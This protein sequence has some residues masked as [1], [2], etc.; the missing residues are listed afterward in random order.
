MKKPLAIREEKGFRYYETGK[1]DVL[2]LLHGLF[3]ALSNFREVIDYFSKKMNVCIPLLPLYQLPAEQTTVEGLVDYIT[4]FIRHKRYKKLILLG[5]SLGGHIA[6]MYALQHP[7]KVRSIV[8]TG[9]SG[10]FENALGDSYPKKSDYDFVRQKT[11]YT[12][13]DPEVAT[14]ELVDEVYEIV[15]NREKALRILYL[16]KSALR[17]N[18]R[19][20]LRKINVPVMLI[21]GKNDKITPAFVAE[22]F[23]ELLPQSELTFID[24]CGHA[25][26]MERADEFN[27]ILDRFLNKLSK[28]KS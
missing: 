23:K 18:L 24:K 10:L 2:L 20:H 25:A 11:Q 6:L 9:S 21:W 1:G 27:L 28:N 7:R 4:D 22:E 3:G 5:N 26:M 13:Y 12:F 19:E 17:N 15:N 16:A 14:K 8:L